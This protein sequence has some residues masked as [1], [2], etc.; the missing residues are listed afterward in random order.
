[1]VAMLTLEARAVDDA[2][3]QILLGEY[4]D[5]RAA[6]RPADAGPYSR[7]TPDPK[8]FAAPEGVLLVASED[9]VALGCGGIR[10]EAATPGHELGGERWF[11]VKHV[12]VRPSA[13]GRGLSRRIMAGLEAAARELGADRLVLDTHTSQ[14]AAAALY[15][16]LGYVE[17]APYN[18][19]QNA[20][21]W[22]GKRL[23]GD[24]AAPAADPTAG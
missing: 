8:R 23:E 4:F 20:N 1:M 15:R 22:F 9:G 24:A 18:G 5:E 3:A 10:R 12:Y 19:N 2:D 6:S 17:V 16:A 11:E 21:L 14:A 7:A 13:R